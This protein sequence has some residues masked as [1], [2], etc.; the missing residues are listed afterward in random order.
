MV[1]QA[2]TNDYFHSWLIC[3]LFSWLI[4]PNPLEKWFTD[5][6]NGWRLIFFQSINGLIIAAVTTEM[7]EQSVVT[8]WSSASELGVSSSSLRSQLCS[9][10]PDSY[11]HSFM[12]PSWWTQT[13]RLSLTVQQIFAALTYKLLSQGTGFFFYFEVHAVSFLPRSLHL[14]WWIWWSVWCFIS[15]FYPLFYFSLLLAFYPCLIHLSVF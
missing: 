2:A 4:S 15:G 12:V 7:D 9:L 6:Q 14:I 8:F 13:D 5:Y 1:A 11:S 10:R 3:R